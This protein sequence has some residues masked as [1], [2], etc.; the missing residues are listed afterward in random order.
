MALSTFPLTTPT[1]DRLCLFID[2]YALIHAEKST[3]IHCLTGETLPLPDDAFARGVSA[4][5][6]CLAHIDEI[7]QLLIFYS[8]ISRTARLRI[9]APVALKMVRMD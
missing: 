5:S 3:T 6:F 1:G 4:I 9:L 2:G 8:K 7:G